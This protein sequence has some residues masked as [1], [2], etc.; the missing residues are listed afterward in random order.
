MKATITTEA[1]GDEEI[2]GT[3]SKVINTVSSG[4]GNSAGGAGG[5]NGGSS[6]AGYKAEITI[7]NSSDLL[8][9]MNA[10]AKIILDGKSDVFA[11]PYDAITTDENGNDVIYIA[12]DNGNG[13]YTVEEMPITKG[14]ETDYYTEIS[15]SGLL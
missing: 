9:G 14:T 3:V 12:K 15:G 8:I 7:D 5:L 2:Q 11:V 13:K 10:K 6:S 4:G 1:T